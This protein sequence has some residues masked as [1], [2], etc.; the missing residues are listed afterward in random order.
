MRPVMRAG[1]AALILALALFLAA[2]ST[3]PQEDPMISSDQAKNDLVTLFDET[4]ETIGGEWTVSTEFEGWDFC[5][6][7][8]GVDGRAYLAWRSAAPSDDL[9]AVAE[10]VQA[11]WESRGFEVTT[12]FTADPDLHEVIARGPYHFSAS[13]GSSAKTMMLTG[14]SACVKAE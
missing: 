5:N 10:L 1:S 2:C 12:R 9:K 3:Q 6:F 8:R 4:A 7:D 14:Q 11:D 13:F